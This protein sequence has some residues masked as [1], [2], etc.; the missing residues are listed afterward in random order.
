MSNRATLETRAIGEGRL[1]PLGS[2]S[3]CQRSNG[4]R[5]GPSLRCPNA[6]VVHA[7]ELQ[8]RQ[9]R[10]T[11]VELSNPM[12]EWLDCLDNPLRRHSAFNYLTRDEYESLR[13]QEIQAAFS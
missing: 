7:V 4:A 13:S 8:N 12:A 2:L 11:A 3:S 6:G 9:S 1:T 5:N 10:K